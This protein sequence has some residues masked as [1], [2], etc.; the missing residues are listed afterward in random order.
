MGSAV[1]RADLVARLGCR[2]P[3]AVID[4]PDTYRAVAHPWPADR[5]AAHDDAARGRGR[6]LV[7]DHDLPERP[8]GLLATAGPRL[9]ALTVAAHLLHLLPATGLDPELDEDLLRSLDDNAADSLYR[10]HLARLAHGEDDDLD[11]W[12][13]LL[14][15]E[16]GNLL[17]VTS[18]DAEPRPLIEH[19]EHADRLAAAAIG[20][21]EGDSGPA[22]EMLVDCHA[23]LLAICVIVDVVTRRNT[24]GSV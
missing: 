19:A 23:R 2:P 24:T 9:T 20:A 10:V 13:P 11:E 8:I 7:G 17:E 15:E 4:L 1:P 6:A 5:L 3:R 16:A 22:M 21:L 14:Y 12:Q 18:P